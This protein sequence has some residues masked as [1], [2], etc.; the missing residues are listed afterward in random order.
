M[1]AFQK[2]GVEVLSDIV[3]NHRMGADEKEKVQAVEE[4][5]NNRYEN[6]SGEMEIEAWTKFTFPG[7]NGKYSTFQWNHNHFDG[8]DW[9]E[10]HQKKAVFRL[11]GKEW[12]LEVDQENGNYDYLMGADLDLGD[13][14]VSRELIN[15]G[16]WY[17]DTTGTDGFRLDAV[18]HM[19]ASFYKEW[20]EAMREYTGKDMFAVGE[21][22]SADVSRLTHYL[23]QS[24]SSM[25]LFDVPLHFQFYQ[26]SNANSAFDMAQLFQGTLLQRD[27]THCVTFVDNHD[28][29][30][31]QALQTFVA[32]WFKPLAYGIILLQEKGT[33]CVFYGDYYGIPHDQRKPVRLLPILMTLRQTHA[34]GKE[35]DYYD[36][37]NIV[38]FTREG[39]DKEHGLALLITDGPGGSKKMYA[40]KEHA[41]Q[42]YL[43]ACGNCG[44]N[45]V[46]DA[47]G[48][49]TFTVDGGSISV[50]IPS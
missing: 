21:Y 34:Y 24:G 12:D 22:W 36:D 8:V 7:R 28:T 41:G 5:W 35:N 2:N 38:G 30:P 1:E 47:D 9:D 27:E 14:E 40:G 4:S 3:L 11:A 26:I 6:R 29:Q 39:Q 48:Y 15:W 31:G 49:G 33:P 19:N 37:Q 18:K 46:I 43:D 20:L 13:P 45:V 50:W 25:S 44:G 42:S 10:P 32:E 16:K 17:I 23:E